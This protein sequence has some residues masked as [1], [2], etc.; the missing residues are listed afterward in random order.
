[1]AG[2]MAPIPGDPVTVEG[3][4]VAGTLLDSGVRAYFA[5]P[6]A[7]PPVG[8]LRWHA[9]MP[10]KPWKGV[11]N[12]D[13]VRLS[14]AGAVQDDIEPMGEDC[15]NLNIWT[16]PNATRA[17]GLPV[18][19]WIH[20]GGFRGG[21]PNLAMYSGVEFA[22]KGLVYVGI[23]YRLG[24]LGF[25]AHPELTKESARSAPGNW[26][27]LDQIAAL[28]W[29]QRNIAAFGG[30]P[31][32]VTIMGES[33]GSESVHLL[34]ATPLAKGLFAKATGWSGAIIPPGNQMVPTLSEAEAQGLKLQ[35]DLHVNSLTEMRALP[36]SRVLAAVGDLRVRRPVLDGYVLPALPVDIFKAG[37]QNDVPVYVSSTAKDKGGSDE[38]YEVKTL[39]DLQTLAKQ[40]FADNAA[41]FFKLFPAA[42][43]AE[44][45]KQ[46][47]VV[48]AGNGFGIS[49]RDWARTQ[50]AT[51]KQPA[52]LAQ[53]ARV[54]PRPASMKGRFSIGA[55]H[56]SDIV[57]WL[58]TQA[59]QP[60]F[61]WTNWDRDLSTM[62][63]DTLVAFARTGNPNTPAVT[64]PRYDPK[65]EQRVVFGDKV[66][67]EK[68]DTAQ[69]EFLRAH[70]TSGSQQ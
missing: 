52:Y 20:G 9:P 55:A 67:T 58:G 25:M 33:A 45:V 28:Q 56:A 15:L 40:A 66:W 13:A 3:G 7:A 65:N 8:D 4:K 6:F 48:V 42:N 64:I 37:R 5:I 46:A 34:Q 21:S 32:N 14:C 16:P 22:K 61:R 1:M 19:V 11:Y 38:F 29:I 63:L 41:E 49:N 30:D 17:S 23:S 12:A 31:A 59:S 24:V 47:Q 53:F 70:P 43:D 51:G 44:A 39:L 18:V 10:A 26:G 50:T 57:Y 2:F 36:W 62:M 69:L 54:A 68:L 35:E 60:T 27:I